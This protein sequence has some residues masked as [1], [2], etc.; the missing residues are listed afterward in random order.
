MRAMRCPVKLVRE[1]T[2]CGKSCGIPASRTASARPQR[3]K[4]SIVRALSAVARGWKIV[5]SSCSTSV[6]L[7]PRRPRSTASASPTGPPPAISTVVACI[8]IP[9]YR[10]ERIRSASPGGD[11]FR[12]DGLDPRALLGRQRDLGCANVLFQMHTALRSAEWDDVVASRQ[13]PR[14]RELCRRQS[15]LTRERAESFDELEILREVLAEKARCP[16]ANVFALEAVHPDG[17]AQETAADRGE[18]N[19]GDPKLTDRREDAVVLDV[20]REER[21]LAL[22]RRY[23]VDPDR[24]PDVL[25]A[26]LGEPQVAHLTGPDELRHRADGFFDRDRGIDAMQI[27]KVDHIDAEPPQRSLARRP[28]VIRAPAETAPAGGIESAT[29]LARQDDPV[30]TPADRASDQLLVVTLTVGIRRIDQRYA[31]LD[32]ALNRRDRFRVVG[33]SIGAGHTPA[34]QTDR[35]NPNPVL[36]ESPL[37]HVLRAFAMI[38]HTH[39]GKPRGC[40]SVDRESPRLADAVERPGMILRAPDDQTGSV[41]VFPSGSC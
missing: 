3:R 7:I 10:R 2:V 13:E 21:I 31:E 23:R 15:E 16:L 30:A 17:R 25:R 38:S 37:D 28:H 24:T 27:I 4:N 12:D 9:L 6:H 41:L 32:R 39:C 33:R 8:A 34:A 11:A 14:E 36:P 5:P 26:R 20:A 40:S 19:E 35:R 1:R 22:Q 29:E 18:R